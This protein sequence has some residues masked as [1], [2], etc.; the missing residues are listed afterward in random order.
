MLKKFYINI[1]SLT[2]ILL[3]SITC[4]HKIPF[5]CIGISHSHSK[6]K[7]W[8]KNNGYCKNQYHIAFWITVQ[9]KILLVIRSQSLLF[10]YL[11][12]ESQ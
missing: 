6:I 11:L 1:S 7:L 10:W 12:I 8:D 9:I 5:K 2:I 4:H 3:H